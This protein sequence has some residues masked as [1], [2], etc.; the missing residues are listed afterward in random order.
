MSFLKVTSFDTERDVIHELTF[1]GVHSAF[2]C[3]PK[4]NIGVISTQFQIYV[5]V[6][7]ELSFAIIDSKVI[8][9]GDSHHFGTDVGRT[10]LIHTPAGKK[11]KTF[12]VLPVNITTHTN[13][14]LLLSNNVDIT[15]SNTHF[16]SNAWHMVV[17]QIKV[18][19]FK[20]IS[21]VSSCKSCTF[22]D[23]PGRK[24][25]II[26]ELNNFY[27]HQKYVLS[28]RTFQM[29]IEHLKH[30]QEFHRVN[31]TFT[32][33]DSGGIIHLTVNQTQTI[34]LPQLSPCTIM[35][36]CKIQLHS[37]ITYFINLTLTSFKHTG[38]VN[39]QGCDFSGLALYDFFSDEVQ[40]LNTICVK[41]EIQVTYTDDCDFGETREQYIYFRDNIHHFDTINFEPT[42]TVSYI[43]AQNLFYLVFYSYLSYS[44]MSLTVLAN[45][46]ACKGIPIRSCFRLVHRAQ[47]V[48][49]FFHN[50]PGIIPSS[51][52]W[53]EPGWDLG[54][55]VYYFVPSESTEDAFSEIFF[56]ID[57]SP[58]AWREMT[59]VFEG[60]LQGRSSVA[61]DLRRGRVEEDDYISKQQKECTSEA[62][63]V[64]L[65]PPAVHA[66]C[67]N[68][69]KSTQY[70]QTLFFLKGSIH[71]STR[72]IFHKNCEILFLLHTAQKTLSSFLFR[73]TSTQSSSQP[74]TFLPFNS[75][76]SQMV[77]E[78]KYLE[79]AVT[80]A[81]YEHPIDIIVFRMPQ[82][83]QRESPAQVCSFSQHSC[84]PIHWMQG[85]KFQNANRPFEPG[86]QMF[87]WNTYLGILVRFTSYSRLLVKQRWDILTG[88]CF[89]MFV[90]W[91]ETN[92]QRYCSS[93]FPTSGH[94]T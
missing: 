81:R 38:D 14:Q 85:Q 51:W 40:L 68:Y 84:F 49:V 89:G 50:T 74:H 35:S 91:K 47:G 70:Q 29:A 73:V 82:Q 65:L 60:I 30:E 8:T 37:Q 66:Y 36:L 3:Y 61:V 22:F 44:Q 52:V 55:S 67:Y 88:Q 26:K 48:S 19:H 94:K 24:A 83:R 6:F 92:Q 87:A 59:F 4:S 32:G 90:D 7:K 75:Y 76:H 78:P 13:I 41:P 80:L 31:H 77:L 5:A 12:I 28:S 86:H 2:S 69:N 9:S 25:G 27:G 46:T 93:R 39:T 64:C 17:F 71:S 21:V 79:H 43:S 33:L 54:C 16:C 62:R 57:R 10:N 1:C 63:C 72:R 15:V 42:D 20:Y 45:V 58:D 18:E 11:L 53:I 34:Q 56:V 23:G